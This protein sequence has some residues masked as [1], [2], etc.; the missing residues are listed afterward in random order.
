MIGIL[1]GRLK[2][3]TNGEL[4]CFPSLKWGEEFFLARDCG[5]ECI[6][7]L[8]EAAYNPYN[9]LYSEEGVDRLKKLSQETG[10]KISSVCVDYFMQKPFWSMDRNV[11][12]ESEKTFRELV[13]KCSAIGAEQMV[14]PFF[15]KAEL[16]TEDDKN[17]FR[18]SL[19]ELAPFAKQHDVTLALEITW[20]AEELKPFME[21]I[22][23]ENVGVCFD[24]GNTT[25]K[26]H[27]VPN[28]IRALGKLVTHVHVKDRRKSDYE[29]VLLGTG[30]ADFKSVFKAFLDVG[31]KGAYILETY[32]GEDPVQTAKTHRSFILEKMKEG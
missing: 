24:T 28:D 6:E 2:Q 31:Y 10:V 25:G 18:N 19:K 7:L 20:P 17:R 14:L 29:N 11:K 1:Q 15:E 5:L 13:L 12:G 21:S 30:D 26:N 16:K 22:D 23:T 27:D 9:P 3:T 32:R 4:Q 8:F